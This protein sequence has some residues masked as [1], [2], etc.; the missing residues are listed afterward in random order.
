[1]IKRWYSLLLIV[2]IIINF[3]ASNRLRGLTGAA[4]GGGGEGGS[5]APGKASGE[6][7]DGGEE[8][9]EDMEEVE[10]VIDSDI[11]R[12]DIK[13]GM[14]IYLMA[15]W[16]LSLMICARNSRKVNRRKSRHIEDRL[17]FAL[18]IINSNQQG[19]DKST[20]GLGTDVMAMQKIITEIWH[21]FDEDGSGE[22]DKRETKAFLLK[23]FELSGIEKQ[24]D[25]EDFEEFYQQVDVT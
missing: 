14:G 12:A 23:T 13:F 2:S 15:L 7:A 11:V 21:E 9:E 18:A 25:D 4:G 16:L 6:G 22:L 24:F 1:M 8:G 10:S 19:G 20:F 17:G 3:A 5:E